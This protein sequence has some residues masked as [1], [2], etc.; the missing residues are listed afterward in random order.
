MEVLGVIPARYDSVRFPGKL[1]SNI[2]GKPLIQWTWENAS[3][4][5]LLD[6]L[7]IACDD[8]RIYKIASDFG[9]KVIMTS[10]KHESGTDRICEAVADIDTKF[11]VNIQGDEPL[12]RHSLIDTLISTMQVDESVVMATVIKEIKSPEEINDYN[13]VKVVVD[14]NNFAIYFSR[15]PIP[16]NRENS[17]GIR[18]FKHIG[19]YGYTKE[20]L[21]IFK[22]LPHSLLEKAERLEQLRALEAGYRIKVVETKDDCVGVDTPQDLK[23]VEEL[24]SKREDV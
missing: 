14:R 24:L 3:K 11:V 16:F 22:N 5:V 1:L 18:Y 23:R 6:D 9:A 13:V 4:S 19:I 2:L 8:S 17:E 10:K 20:F 21:Y 12:I 7:I 15:Y